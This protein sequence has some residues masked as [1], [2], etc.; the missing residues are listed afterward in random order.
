MKQ[1]TYN[2]DWLTLAG[3]LKASQDIEDGFWQL[4]INTESVTTLLPA[5]ADGAVQM[6]LPGH[7][8]RI[9][10]FQLTKAPHLGFMC[11]QVENGLITEVGFDL[12][13]NQ[14]GPIESGEGVGGD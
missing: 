6:V 4:S 8:V 12:N 2:I 1:V 13:R 14:N 11:F 5:L 10:G 9:L 3:A 7:A